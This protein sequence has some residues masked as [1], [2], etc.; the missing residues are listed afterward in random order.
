MP[1][2]RVPDP[3]ILA[4]I[5]QEAQAM[6]REPI[7]TDSPFVQEAE[8][9]FRRLTEALERRHSLILPPPLPKTTS[10]E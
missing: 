3:A 10:N 5:T 1:G 2:E 9:Q 7:P 4:Q 8:I 6:H